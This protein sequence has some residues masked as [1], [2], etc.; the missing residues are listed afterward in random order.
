MKV[1]NFMCESNINFCHSFPGKQLI[2]IFNCL[3]PK[4]KQNKF[5]LEKE[6]LV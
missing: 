5:K 1:L 2:F 3:L 6:T 4:F